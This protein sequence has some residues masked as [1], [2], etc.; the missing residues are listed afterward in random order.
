ESFTITPAIASVGAPVTFR[1][2]VTEDADGVVPTLALEDDADNDYDVSAADPLDGSID[3]QFD[4]AGTYVFTL[5]A[6]TPGKDPV[7]ATRTLEVVELPEVTSFTATPSTYTP[8]D[9]AGVVLEWASTGG[10]SVTIHTVVGG[11]VSGAPLFE[12]S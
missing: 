7:E 5:T 8:G 6:T 2:V 12:D 9:P 4:A 1:W 11:S 10:V 3:L